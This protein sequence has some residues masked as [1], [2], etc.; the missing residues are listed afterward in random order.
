MIMNAN[1]ENKF[2]FKF[3]KQ[4]RCQQDFKMEPIIEYLRVG[5]EGW[6]I[7]GGGGNNRQST[8]GGRGL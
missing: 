3:S 2:G 1:E 4:H 8:K 5:R 7:I 6:K